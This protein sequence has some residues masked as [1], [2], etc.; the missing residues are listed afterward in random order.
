ML[1]NTTEDEKYPWLDKD[2]K[3]QNIMDREIIESRVN[4]KD[5]FII[6]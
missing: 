3:R 5:F 2:H 6:K 1:I 4:L